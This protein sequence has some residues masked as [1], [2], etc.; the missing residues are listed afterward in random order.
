MNIFS[1]QYT[2]M[3]PFWMTIQNEMHSMTIILY[4]IINKRQDLV[5]STTDHIIINILVN[6]SL[7]IYMPF[8]KYIYRYMIWSINSTTGYTYYL[9][10]IC[11]HRNSTAHKLLWSPFNKLTEEWGVEKPQSNGP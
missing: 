11:E 8:E 7:Y 10:L 2:F 9:L 4:F 6:T 1:C 5:F 3:P